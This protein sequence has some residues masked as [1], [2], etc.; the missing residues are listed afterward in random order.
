MPS[1]YIKVQ[2]DYITHLTFGIHIHNPKSNIYPLK[3]VGN[4]HACNYYKP[5]IY[6]F[7]VIGI[8]LILFKG[9][10]IL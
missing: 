9:V 2:W 3:F 4:K 10:V 6:L 1:S 5:T 8:V 7:V